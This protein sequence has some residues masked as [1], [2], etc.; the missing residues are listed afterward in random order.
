[1]P[2]ENYNNSSKDDKKI[3]L[4]IERFSKLN[5]K[6]LMKSQ[7]RNKINFQEFLWGK[8]TSDVK[9]VRRQSGN[10]I[11]NQKRRTLVRKELI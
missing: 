6:S 9:S 11:L 5:R 4:K 1:M 8:I 10:T 7:S 3:K 2:E